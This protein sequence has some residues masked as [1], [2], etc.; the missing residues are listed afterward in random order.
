MEGVQVI[1]IE[2]KIPTDVLLGTV[3]GNLGMWVG[4]SIMTILEMFELLFYAIL[5]VPFFFFGI[6]MSFIQKRE[7][8]A[9]TT[10]D[11]QTARFLVIRFGGWVWV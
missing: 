4:M 8:R 7:V 3:G 6:K 1:S 11:P 5:A 2:D 9:P 10:C